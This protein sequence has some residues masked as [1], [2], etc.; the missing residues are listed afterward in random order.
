MVYVANT[1][2]GTVSVIDGDRKR[3]VGTVLAGQDPYALT[4]N[5]VSHKVHVANVHQDSDFILDL[6]GIPRKSSPKR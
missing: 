3:L 1:Q 4:V 5:P 6:Q 2:S